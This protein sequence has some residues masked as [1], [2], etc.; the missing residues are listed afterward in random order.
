MKL[1]DLVK[2]KTVHFKFYRAGELWYETE[3]GF[4]F[5]VPIE[6]CGYATFLNKDKATI[7]MRYIRSQLEAV[8]SGNDL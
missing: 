3:D 2:G 8:K 1:I 4:A 6:D 5:P 7:F